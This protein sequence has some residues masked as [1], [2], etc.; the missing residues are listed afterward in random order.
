MHRSAWEIASS[1]LAAER[2]QGWCRISS[3][4]SRQTRY[5][6]RS[7]EINTMSIE[8]PS[9]RLPGNEPPSGLPPQFNQTH[10]PK[11]RRSTQTWCAL[12]TLTGDN[13]VHNISLTGWFLAKA[14]LRDF[15]V[16]RFRDIFP[17]SHDTNIWELNY[18]NLILA[19]VNC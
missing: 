4:I 14:Q 1:G 5:S 17:V 6:S 11:V 15:A 12:T 3:R 2:V 16:A 10:P 18:N 9:L 8:P 19:E 13:R 7:S